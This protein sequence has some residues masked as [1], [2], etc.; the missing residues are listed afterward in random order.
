MF[1]PNSYLKVLAMSTVFFFLSAV[2]GFCGT[3]PER[4]EQDLKKLQ[5][6]FQWW[7]SDAQPQ[8]VKDKSSGGYWWWPVTPGEKRPWGNRGYIYVYKIIFDYKSEEL[9]PPKPAE[10]RPSLLIKKILKNVKIYFDFDNASLRDDASPILSSAVKAL[11]KNPEASIL[12]TGNCD[13]RGSEKY[14]LKLGRLRADAV[15]KFMIDNGIL[16]DRI[17]IISR[18]KLDAVARVTD[19]AGMQKDRNAQFMVAE[20]EEVMLPYEGESVPPDAKMI[21]EGK[22]VEEKEEPVESAVKVSTKEYVVQKGDSLWRIAEKEFGKGQ[23]HRWKYIYELNKGKIKNPKKLKAG[24]TILI[25][26]E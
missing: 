1:K 26:I 8:P 4:K 9:P 19:L 23:G 15:K 5:E 12:I 17:K 24:T 25:P 18:G 6:K 13:T 2:P 21:E 20:V 22:F 11:E 3:D 7:P 16:E 14:N 10:K